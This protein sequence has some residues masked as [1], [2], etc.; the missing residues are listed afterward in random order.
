[1]TNVDEIEIIFARPRKENESL[2]LTIPKHVCD[3]LRISTGSR[4]DLIVYNSFVVLKQRESIE[5]ER[6]PT[7]KIFELLDRVFEAFRELRKLERQRYDEKALTLSE[8]DSQAGS[9]AHLGF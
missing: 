7:P 4:L 3:K 6:E 1:M 2:V 5:S 8:Y 9:Q